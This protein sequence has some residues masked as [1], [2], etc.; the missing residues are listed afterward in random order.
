MKSI[1]NS[2]KFLSKFFTKSRKNVFSVIDVSDS[3]GY[4]H[5]PFYE[6][7]YTVRNIT[8]ETSDDLF[9]FY[10]GVN[11]IP[12]YISSTSNKTISLI[13]NK[14]KIVVSIVNSFYHSV[15]DN[16][17]EILYSIKSYPDH[18]LVIDISEI[19]T[20]LNSLNNYHNSFMYFIEILKKRKIKYKLVSLKKY[21]IIYINDF[22]VMDYYCEFA[23]KAELVY[24]FF[25][26]TFSN[27][28]NK[29]HRNIFVSRA[30][31]IGRDYEEYSPGLGY[32]ND[33]RMDDHQKLEDLFKSFGYEIIDTSIFASFK[34][35][36]EYFY[37]AKTIASITGSGLTNAAFMR[38]GQTLI[39]IVTP[40]VV[41]VG[42]P[43]QQKD[44]TDPYYVQEIHNFYKNLAFYKNH[45]YFG[46]HNDARSFDLLKQTI[47]NDPKIKNFLD[48]SNE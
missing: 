4:E 12:G 6:G 13:S 17:S 8:P 24:E 43:Y 28:K 3:P 18:E 22:R 39:E 11:M 1:E 9:Y 44:I 47:D 23:Q 25:K 34:D 14:K 31:N 33:D 27:L 45:T 37:E 16:M 48:R 41:P 30:K 15:L 26:P 29:P 32:K 5:L 21:E 10:K 7:I 38:P 46:I 42:R 36:V 35:Q 20:S 19:E 40:L 2:T